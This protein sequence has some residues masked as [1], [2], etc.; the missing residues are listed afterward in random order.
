MAVTAVTR[1][2]LT[3]Y[4]VLGLL[5]HARRASSGYDLTKAAQRSV[6]YIWSPS[7]TQLYAVLGRLVAQGLATRR[8]VPQDD[9][10]DKSLYRIT[11]KGRRAMRDWLD[12]ETIEEDVERQPFLLKLF[13]ARHGD[14]DAMIRQLEAYRAAAAARLATYRGIERHIVE[15]DRVER[16]FGYITLRFGIARARAT[17]RWA[18][19]TLAEL[20]R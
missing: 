13:F 19:E 4:A 1:L 11:A 12:D 17:I 6:G 5:A 2:S 9:R 16:H 8:D 7:K 10:P 15:H 14:P 20:R 18:D 3:E